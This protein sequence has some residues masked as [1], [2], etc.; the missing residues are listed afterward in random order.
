MLF[1]DLVETQMDNAIGLAAWYYTNEAR[2]I[3]LLF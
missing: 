2:P 1:K 3:I